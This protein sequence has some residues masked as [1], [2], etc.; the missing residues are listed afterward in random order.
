MLSL[1]QSG[2]TPKK[3]LPPLDNVDAKLTKVWL[4]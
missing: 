1:A 4:E 2:S 3:I